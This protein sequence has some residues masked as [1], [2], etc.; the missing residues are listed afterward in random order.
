[1]IDLAR[2]KQQGEELAKWHISEAKWLKE[3][4]PIEGLE[5]IQW[6]KEQAAFVTSLLTALAEK[7]K[8]LK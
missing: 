3:E 1:M 7:E 5:Q 2:L 6:H 8:D 4:G